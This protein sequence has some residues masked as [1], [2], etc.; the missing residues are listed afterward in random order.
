LHKRKTLP[1]S[2]SDRGVLGKK[3][4]IEVDNAGNQLVSV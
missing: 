1:E 2:A 3:P 4:I